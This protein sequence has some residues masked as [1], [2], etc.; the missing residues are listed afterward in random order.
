MIV[1]SK[2]SNRLTRSTPNLK[3]S[4]VFQGVSDGD[5]REFQGDSRGFQGHPR[6][7]SGTF[8]GPGSRSGVGGLRRF[9][10]DE[11]GLRGYTREWD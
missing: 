6:E 8:K 10:W 5:F 4:G 11:K 2:C 9:Q 1:K 7:V 3:V